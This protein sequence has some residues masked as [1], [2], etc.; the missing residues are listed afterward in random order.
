M[1]LITVVVIIGIFVCFVKLA[2][3]LFKLFIYKSR[4]LALSILIT[5]LLELL[6][7]QFLDDTSISGTFIFIFLFPCLCLL[8]LHLIS[9]IQY[10]SFQFFEYVFTFIIYI[11]SEF[12]L[13]IINL[14]IRRICGLP[15]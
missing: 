8:V 5:W 2:C 9:K 1:E 13:L 11:L 15:F 12:I 7:M 3:F 6:M 10:I 14:L 4:F